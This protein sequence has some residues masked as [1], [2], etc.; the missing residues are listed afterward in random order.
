MTLSIFRSFFTTS[1]YEF[2]STKVFSFPLKV[3]PL[4]VG[5]HIA[6]P[7]IAKDCGSSISSCGQAVAAST[8]DSLSV[9]DWKT[10]PVERHT[11]VE[12]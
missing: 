11:G 4:L 10:D 2:F 6:D 12:F 7:A 8:M 1:H 5:L 9:M 3:F